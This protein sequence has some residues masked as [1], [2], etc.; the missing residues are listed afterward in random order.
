MSKKRK[1]WDDAIKQVA[2]EAGTKLP[3][4]RKD[5]KRETRRRVNARR[6]IATSDQDDLQRKVECRLEALEET[7]YDETNYEEEDEEWQDE[8]AP[9]GRGR[10]AKAK[11][12]KK[13]K[14]S[15]SG[16][17]GGASGLAEFN[18]RFPAKPLAHWLLEEHAARADAED[19]VGF[20]AAE[21]APSK[22]PAR[23]LC[24]MT[25]LVAKYCDPNANLG[26]ATRSAGAQLKDTPPPWLHSSGNAPY[27]DAARM[28]RK[29]VADARGASQS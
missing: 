13:L 7:N 18:K 5:S 6:W 29:E 22:V 12:A 11:A 28:I 1:A 4:K 21:A 14:R 8:D 20:I 9:V 16:A 26:F 17:S 25:G 19:L 24:A 2:L 10:K 23:R 27:F 15:G 3:S